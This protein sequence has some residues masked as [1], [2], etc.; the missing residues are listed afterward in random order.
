MRCIRGTGGPDPDPTLGGFHHMSVRTFKLIGAAGAA[1][2]AVG[3]LA[4]PA[5]GCR[6]TGQR[7]PAPAGRR[8]GADP[9]I[10]PSTPVA[11]ARGQLA[12]GQTV[13]TTATS[14]STRTPS[15]SR[16]GLGWSSFAAPSSPSPSATRRSQP[17]D[18]QDHGARRRAAP[19]TSRRPARRSTGTK[20]GT[21]TVKAGRP[22]H[23]AP[24]RL[25]PA[26]HHAPHRRPTSRA[27]AS[28]RLHTTAPDQPDRSPRS[29]SSPRTPPRP[30][31]RRR[32]TPRRTS[33]PGTATVAGAKFKLAGTGKVK[34]TLKKG[35]K[36][37]KSITAT[38]TRRARPRPPS[39][40]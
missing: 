37:V 5:T 29:R 31:P 9:P 12:V 15:A 33:P 22:G 26:G 21:F 13:A 3:A 28:S 11:S 27:A 19:S 20:V 4:G 1:A 16:S 23:V 34:F 18:P 24:Q 14:T 7:T 39:R 35:T 32:T 36:T 25:R 17:E 38:L 10:G 30:P 8:L 2:L 40:A 6:I